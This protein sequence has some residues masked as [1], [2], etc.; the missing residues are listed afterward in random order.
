MKASHWPHDGCMF[1][2]IYMKAA[3][4]MHGWPEFEATWCP[5]TCI[6]M[7]L[8]IKAQFTPHHLSTQTLSCSQ[9]RMTHQKPHWK[10]E[11]LWVIFQK[12][13]AVT[14]TYFRTGHHKKTMTI[15]TV[16]TQKH[17]RCWSFYLM[18]WKL[19]FYERRKNISNA[20]HW[21]TL[22]LV[23]TQFLKRVCPGTHF[24]KFLARTLLEIWP[25]SND[26]RY[27]RLIG[28]PRLPSESWNSEEVLELLYLVENISTR[29][30]VGS[31][32]VWPIQ[33]HSREID[34]GPFLPQL[35]TDWKSS[36]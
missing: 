16:S 17:D 24:L 13:V 3:S 6:T 22:F 34:E 10:S 29:P 30:N 27:N 5:Q 1:W 33:L 11:Y 36:W 23:G 35:M 18:Y 15:G 4:R 19:H 32:T 9:V 28:T 20:G 2:C 26:C 21:D 7:L 12:L 25:G 14:V 31:R 8:K